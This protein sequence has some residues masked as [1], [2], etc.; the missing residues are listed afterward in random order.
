MVAPA[1][2]F[3]FVRST[4]GLGMCAVSCEHH[5]DV[6]KSPLPT[7]LN[8]FPRRE[9]DLTPGLAGLVLQ[10]GCILVWYFSRGVI[11][12]LICLMKLSVNSSCLHLAHL[13]PSAEVHAG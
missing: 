13:L 9:T 3:V 1:K 11:M 2:A 4:V 7:E 8:V 12:L 6:M 5:W 10:S